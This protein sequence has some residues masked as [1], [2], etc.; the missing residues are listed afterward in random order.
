VAEHASADRPAP[1]APT[2]ARDALRTYR[3]LV[4][5][6]LRSQ[7]QYRTSFAFDVVQSMLTTA[8]GY[9]EVLAVFSNVRVLGDLDVRRALL[10]YGLATL[11]FGIANGVVGQLDTIPDYIRTGTLEV[12]LVRPQPVLAQIVTSDVQLRRLGSALVGAGT[13]GVALVVNPITWTPAHVALLVLTPL[14]GALLFAALFV[15]A[16]AL[17]FWLVDAAEVTSSFTYGANYAAEFSAAVFPVP[18][19]LLFA[20]AVPASFAAY[21]PAA[22]VLGLPGPVWVPAW[23]GWATP[24]VAGAAWGLAL[25]FWRRGL[26]HY[27]GA[28][29]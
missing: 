4:A 8:T 10:V 7:L 24:L 22:A 11:G 13:V 6:R 17:Q 20:F 15:A 28:G 25:L 5:S 27:S 19:R 2:P 1:W 3:T 23:L 9:V 26:R 29:G 14:T 21:L 16:G 18:L 12:F